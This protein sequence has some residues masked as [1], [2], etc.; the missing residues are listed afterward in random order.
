MAKQGRKEKTKTTPTRVTAKKIDRYSGRQP[1]KNVSM[2]MPE[3]TQEQRTTRHEIQGIL[4]GA[5]G[6][7]SGYQFIRR[8]KRFGTSGWKKSAWL[9]LVCG[10]ALLAFLGAGDYTDIMA[11][12]FGF[13]SGL[14]LGTGYAAFIRRPPASVFQYTSIII[15]FSVLALSW[16]Q[17]AG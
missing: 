12:F 6:I 5:V 7:L 13:V 11:H 10:I 17:G 4:F 16:I 15:A 14:L 1:R 3:E 2:N 8:V 9:P